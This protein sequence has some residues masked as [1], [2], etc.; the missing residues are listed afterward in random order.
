LTFITLVT[1]SAF[2]TANSIQSWDWNDGTTQDWMT[3]GI[4]ATIS[5]TDGH[6]KVVTD[7]NGSI[8]VWGPITS[9]SGASAISFR[10]NLLSYS[11]ANTPSDLTGGVALRSQGQGTED[12]FGFAAM[13]WDIDFSELEFGVWNEFSFSLNDA[14]EM[15]YGDFVYDSDN[16]NI[17][18]YISN[19]SGNIQHQS[20]MYIDDFV[21]SANAVPVPAAAWLF[22]SALIGLG[23][24]RKK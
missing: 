9:L 14:I 15:N 21:V 2:T 23:I 16:V 17:E 20:T 18:F 13:S 8:Q 12:M 10:A 5:G 3:S 11:T 24:C 7:G 4:A 6:L 19:E 1:F 22:G